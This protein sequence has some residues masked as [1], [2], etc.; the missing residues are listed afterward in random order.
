MSKFTLPSLRNLLA[1]D[2]PLFYGNQQLRCIPS[3]DNLNSLVSPRHSTSEVGTEEK[4]EEVEDEEEDEMYE[5]DDDDDEEEEDG[6]EEVEGKDKVREVAL[7]YYQEYQSQ[8]QALSNFS[9]PVP[10]AVLP[11]SNLNL[12]IPLFAPIA[13]CTRCKKTCRREKRPRTTF[14]CPACNLHLCCKQRRNCFAT[15]HIEIENEKFQVTG[16]K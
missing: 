16:L 3:I 8:S 6:E 11:D 2:L 1:D 7:R 14:F 10:N 13:Y 15:H 9:F 5:K 4:V 12:H